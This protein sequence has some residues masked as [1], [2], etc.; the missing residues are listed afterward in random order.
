LCSVE[1]E[2]PSINAG[3]RSAT[4]KFIEFLDSLK[5]EFVVKIDEQEFNRLL[6]YSQFLNSPI[7]EVDWILHHYQ[8]AKAKTNVEQPEFEHLK[9]MAE[10]KFQT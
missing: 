4:L 5:T 10:S 8:I 6:E 3:K 2:S 1:L 7:K 9:T